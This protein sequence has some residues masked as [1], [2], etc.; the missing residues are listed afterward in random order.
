MS[1]SRGLVARRVERFSDNTPEIVNAPS[2]ATIQ[3]VVAP[4]Q[5][6]AAPAQVVVAPAQAEAA[7]AQV[8]AAPAQVVVAPAQVIVQTGY[9]VQAEKKGDNMWM[10]LIL[11][12][13]VAWWFMGKKESS[14]PANLFSNLA[15]LK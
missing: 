3:V 13:I 9:G 5:V 8:E 1:C 4:A 6:E 7:P 10:W 15:K 14:K 11:L 12:A 2:N